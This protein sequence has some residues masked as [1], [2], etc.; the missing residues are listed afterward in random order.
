WAPIQRTDRAPG[1]TGGGCRTAAASAVLT[2]SAASASSIRTGT[3]ALRLMRRSLRPRHGERHGR[4]LARAR[5]GL[6]V[7]LDPLAVGL[8][9]ADVLE[10]FVVLLRE[11]VA[12]AG[13]RSATGHRSREGDHAVLPAGRGLVRPVAEHVEAVERPG[14]RGGVVAHVEPEG[15]RMRVLGRL[16]L[17]V[18]AGVPKA[19]EVALDADRR[20][21]GMGGTERGGL[22]LARAGP[23]AGE[24]AELAELGARLRNRHRGLGIGGAGGQG[25]GKG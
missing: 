7:D 1:K 12:R 10:G 20:L 6:A 23:V 19:A 24:V 18:A 2:E 11:R 17:L 16:L 4:L 14:V 3:V 5:T 9:L 22:G 13:A 25:G 21:R 8:H 15:H